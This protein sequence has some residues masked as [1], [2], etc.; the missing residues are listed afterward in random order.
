MTRSSFL[1]V[2]TSRRSVRKFNGD[3][4]TDDEL[5]AVLDAGRHAPSG[6]NNQ[7]W[8]FVTIRGGAVKEQLAALTAYGT[9]VRTAD[10]LVAVF[11]DNPRCYDRD[12][13][14]MALG[15]CIQNML[16]A[17]HSLDIGTV[18]LGEILKNRDAV[19]T[20]LAMPDSLDLAGVVALG[21]YDRRP[22]SPG[23]REIDE[24]VVGRF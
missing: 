4:V 11:L 21:R 18:W 6:H 3:A 5:A 12:K 17:A 19:R 20:L 24:I 8:A 7:P 2:I 9:I 15:A 1:D 22:R 10:C 16:L 23:R 14:L 13:D